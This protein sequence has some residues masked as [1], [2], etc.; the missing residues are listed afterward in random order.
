[1]LNT[2]VS[3]LSPSFHC[4]PGFTHIFQWTDRPSAEY[5]A[6]THSSVSAH[7][8]LNGEMRVYYPALEQTVVYRAGD[9][10][11]VPAKC[12]HA[13]TVGAQGCTYMVGEK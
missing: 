4:P 8:L 13:A 12:V 7:Y 10:F 2:S 9:R 5:P 6:H 11:D 1:M 3:G